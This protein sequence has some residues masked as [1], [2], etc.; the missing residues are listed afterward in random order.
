MK[1]YTFSAMCKL[2]F[3]SNLSVTTARTEHSLSLPSPYQIGAVKASVS[4]TTAARQ[5]LDSFKDVLSTRVADHVTLA[6]GLTYFQR[7]KVCVCKQ[8]NSM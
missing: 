4:Y 8:L 5:A 2:E 6:E 3:T 1:C 7:D